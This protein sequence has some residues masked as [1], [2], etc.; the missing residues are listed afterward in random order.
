MTQ[1][2]AGG[3]ARQVMDDTP[4][5]TL[6]LV[7]S[8][9][10]LR[11]VRFGTVD[12]EEGAGV[13]GADG[14]RG[15]AEA[16]AHLDAARGALLAALGMPGGSATAP[17]LP[18]LDLADHTPF[19]QAVWGALLEIPRGEV[20][21]YGEIAQAVGCRSARAVGQAVG[22]NPV[23]VLVPC[24]RV[25]ASGGQLGGFSGGLDLKVQLLGLEGFR[26]DAAR[27]GT[28]L[29]SVAQSL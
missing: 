5:G 7:A 9:R 12:Q 27:F 16:R 14:A 4:V 29:H 10:G 28:R 6:T 13:A 26:A 21:T 23:P 2:T 24:H 19:R 20:R 25:V 22:A 11:E 18:T 3:W 8:E 17:H 1:R 15:A